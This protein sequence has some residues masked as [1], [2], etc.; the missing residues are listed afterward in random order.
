MP[1]LQSLSPQ[2]RASPPLPLVLVLELGTIP[3]GKWMEHCFISKICRVLLAASSTPFCQLAEGPMS[4]CCAQC[5][6]VG[7]VY[8]LHGSSWGR[9]LM[10]APGCSEQRG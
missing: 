7:M 4:F 1:D 8:L 9:A 6:G 10:T 2:H 3:A 5:C